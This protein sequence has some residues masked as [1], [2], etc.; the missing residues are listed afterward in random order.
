MRRLLALLFVLMFV[1]ACGATPEATDAPTDN[2]PAPTQEAVDDSATPTR[3]GD[4]GL[5]LPTETGIEGD[6]G[7]GFGF[8]SDFDGGFLANINGTEIIGD[9]AYNCESDFYIIQLEEGASPQ[10]TLRVRANLQPGT[11]NFGS[12]G[13]V[14]ASLNING[15]VA[16]AESGVIVINDFAS[17]PQQPVRGSFAFTATLFNAVN[18]VSGEFDFPAT[19]DSTFCN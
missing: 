11:Y 3:E 19:A 2:N 7:S 13:D 15:Q 5:T 4:D 17:E 8:N 16:N 9:G 14:L 10:V 1:A 12:G 6:P 18:D